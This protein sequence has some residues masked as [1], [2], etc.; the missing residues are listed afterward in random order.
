MRLMTRSLILL[1]LILVAGPGLHLRAAEK[2]KPLNFVFILVDDLGYMDVGCNN[3]DTVDNSK[4]YS[5]LN[6]S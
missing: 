2:S 6:G 3:P 4:M 5:K 1:A